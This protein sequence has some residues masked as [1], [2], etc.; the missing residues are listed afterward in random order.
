MKP[1]TLLAGLA[2]AVTAT[3]QPPLDPKLQKLVEAVA[4][5]LPEHEQAAEVFE[6]EIAAL[7]TSTD[8]NVVAAVESARLQ[9]LA[10][11]SVRT[12][13]KQQPSYLLFHIGPAN[14]V[15]WKEGA[16]YFLECAKKNV[17]PFAGMTHGVR[18]FRSRMD[19][20]LLLYHVTLPKDYDA[21][22]KYPL[23]VNLHSGGG[24]TWLAYWVKGKPDTNLRAASTDGAIHMT[25]VGRQHIGIGEVAILEAIGHVQKHYAVDP[26]R[27]V[28]GGASW[29]G[30][31]GFHFGT[32]LPDRF[33]AAHTL[34]GGGNYNVPVGN[35]RYDA[36]MLADNLANLPF[37][38]WDS[39]GDGH[40]K[41]NHAFADGLRRR[42]AKHSGFYPHL[43]LTDP[44]G[45][46]GIIER[47]LQDEG[48]AWISR[49]VRNPYPKLVV[50][51]THWLRYDGAYWACIDTVEDPSRAAR[52]EAE[53]K[54]ATCRVAVDNV[55]RLHLDLAPAL[56]GPF[57]ELS[58]RINEGAELK[59]AAGKTV[60]FWKD[61]N[62]WSTSAE[63]YPK[64]LIKKHGRSGPI[65][66]VFM[67]YPV[68]MVHGK[69]SPEAL[70]A[71]V[72]RL[73]STGDGS[74]V[75]RTGFERK[76]AGAVS[77]RDLS[78]KNLI[79]VGDP[80][81]NSLLAKIVDRLPVAFL[82]DGVK[83]AGK[84]YRGPGVSLAM[85]YPN[86]LNPE[87]YVLLLP[88]V[89][90]GGKPLDY[91]DYVI[92]QTIKGQT[93]ILAKGNFDAQWRL[94]NPCGT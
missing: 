1:L 62:G 4:K 31:G 44:K 32:F 60:Y 35:G 30:T 81:Q 90:V 26:D 15:R 89:Y 71:I 36:Y 13:L 58:V 59:V 7:S 51:Q 78:E 5:I 11:R 56:V 47:K 28:I 92:F 63:R 2:L 33:A 85:V 72:D 55:G 88:E 9:I 73:I 54:D 25:P 10:T 8:A 93:R 41:A 67:E 77:D 42:A 83:I 22:K 24:F 39:P 91:P 21:T 70:D 57:K 3:A 19:G 6:K 76:E 45:G 61:A 40:F 17:D 82:D 94:P 65:Q 84:E 86:P 69:Q 20:Q 75:L 49:Q 64:G 66:D 38:I 87:R 23:R 18:T 16:E 53:I 29:G 80:K 68:L 37:V 34:T 46:H 79:L 50:F 43:E 27:I 12:I 52:I 14:L 48:W 74:G